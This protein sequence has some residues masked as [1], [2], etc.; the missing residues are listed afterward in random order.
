MTPE[1]GTIVACLFQ[2]VHTAKTRPA[3]IVSTMD[4]HAAVPMS[5]WP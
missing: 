4:Y 5:S 3:V 2:G 1:P